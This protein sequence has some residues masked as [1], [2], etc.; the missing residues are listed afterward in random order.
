MEGIS[1][2]VVRYYFG[3]FPPKIEKSRNLGPNFRSVPDFEPFSFQMKAVS[4]EPS[5]WLSKIQ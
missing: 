4:L 5:Y 2:P 3:I 1:W